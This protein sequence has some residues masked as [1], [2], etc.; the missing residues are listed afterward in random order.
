MRQLMVVKA[1]TLAWRDVAEPTPSSA[2]DAVV[3]PFVGARCDGD[4]MFLRHDFDG[5]LRAGAMMHLVDEAFRG[6]STNPFS[7]AFAY[8]HEC[9]A[10]VTAC[11]ADVRRF[12]V[13]DLVIE[14]AAI[15]VARHRRRDPLRLVRVRPSSRR[16]TLPAACSL[17]ASS[18]SDDGPSAHGAGTIHGFKGH[19]LGLQRRRNA[20]ARSSV[21][22]TMS[23]DPLRFPRRDLL[24][25]SALGPSAL[26]CACS[27]TLAPRRGARP[28]RRQ[29]S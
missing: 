27:E 6:R 9:V 18:S 5:I 22:T 17:L 23:R 29:L 19:T 25:A 4:A 11:G 24:L 13:G 26:C 21:A 3:R 1:R 15:T 16:T 2:T 8:G 7:P 28:R 10:E 20:S 12:R 14:G